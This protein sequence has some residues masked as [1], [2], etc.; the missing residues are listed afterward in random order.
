MTDIPADHIS[1]RPAVLV[2]PAMDAVV[3]RRDV[4]YQLGTDVSRT[5]DL[6]YPSGVASSTR[7]PAVIF[8][9]GGADVGFRRAMGCLFKEMASTTSWARLVAASGMIGIA[10]SN[11]DADDIYAVLRHVRRYADQLGIDPTR[12]GIWASSGNVPMALSVLMK[13]SDIACAALLYGYMLDWP[14]STLVADTLK[15]WGFANP[16]A[17]KSIKD[18]PVGLP[19]FL[20]RAGREQFPNLNAALDRFIVDGL[21]RNLPLK[22]VNLPNAQ[23]AFDVVEDSETAR[24]AIHACLAF[25]TQNLT[26]TSKP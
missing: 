1:R 4:P 20:V 9:S 19:L 2:L 17:E 3:V 14:G 11:G 23:H 24:G 26:A 12:I 7:L 18:F 13:D 16:A 21:A 22:L 25:L 15:T 10:Y 8:V 5:L 6:Y